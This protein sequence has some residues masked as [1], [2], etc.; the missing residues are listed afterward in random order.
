MSL[1]DSSTYFYCEDC[2]NIYVSDYHINISENKYM[3]SY[4]LCNKC[5]EKNKTV[6]MKLIRNSR[7]LPEKV[8]V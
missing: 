1:S 8:L 7:R 3:N 2:G 5:L 4:K 6:F